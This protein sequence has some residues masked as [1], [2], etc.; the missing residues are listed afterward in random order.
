MDSVLLTELLPCYIFVL[1][2]VHS[3]L[4]KNNISFHAQYPLNY[5]LTNSMGQSPSW[6]ANRFSASQVNLHILYNPKVYYRIHK[7]P[8]PVPIMSHINQVH[9]THSHFL[10]NHFNIILSSK[11]GFSKLLFPSG[12]PTRTLF[13]PLPHT[14]YINRPFY[15]F[16]FYHPNN[17]VKRKPTWCHLFY[18]FIQCSFNAQHVSWCVVS[19]CSLKHYVLQTA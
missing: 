9:V 2:L 18:Y 7:S 17:W 11:L 19:L 14:C 4:I 5:K 16:W 1:Y 15:S 8:P 13:S 12:F 6:K 3:F 10:K